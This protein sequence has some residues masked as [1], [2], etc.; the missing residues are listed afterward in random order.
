LAI[1]APIKYVKYIYW[2]PEERE[3]DL[4]SE[5]DSS[6]IRL[7]SAKAVVCTGLDE[8]TKIISVSPD[9]W[10]GTCK[11]QG[12]WYRRSDKNGQ[13]LIISSFELEGFE[14][15]KAAVITRSDFLLP[16][17]VTREEKEE[18]V[19]D[20]EFKRFS[21]MWFQTLKKGFGQDG[22]G[23]LGLRRAGIPFFSP[24]RHATLILSSPVFL[25][26]PMAKKSPIRLTGVRIYVRAVWSFFR[27]LAL[28]G[29]KNWLRR[30]PVQ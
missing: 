28:H 27:L 20:E 25:L 14:R 5:L 19:R 2:L 11:R 7:K 10:D 4:R 13:Y 21:G 22:H 16:R 6:N 29:G 3:K 8:I 9:V 18:M 12:S 17:L 26:S 30:A 1:K 23:D 15:Y 24:I